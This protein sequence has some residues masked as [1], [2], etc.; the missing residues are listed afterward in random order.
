MESVWVC[1]NRIGNIDQNYCSIPISGTAA[2][3]M[4]RVQASSPFF[5]YVDD[6]LPFWTD[7]ITSFCTEFLL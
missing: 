5:L 6:G 3:T 4:W 2:C 7:I 1:G